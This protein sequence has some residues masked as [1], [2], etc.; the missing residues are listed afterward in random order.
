MIKAQQPN[1]SIKVWCSCFFP[2]CLPLGPPQGIPANFPAQDSNGPHPIPL[3]EFTP[4]EGVQDRGTQRGGQHA[5]RL[6]SLVRAE[7]R[8]YGKLQHVMFYAHGPVRLLREKV[9]DGGDA[10]RA[11]LPEP[12]PQSL[13]RLLRGQLVV[14]RV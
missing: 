9:P 4:P 7:R 14:R 5:N 6:D 3:G 10:R 2:S 12:L 13:L 8:L 11:I 1:E